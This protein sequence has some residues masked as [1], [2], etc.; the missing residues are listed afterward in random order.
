MRNLK[1]SILI[2]ISTLLFS[3]IEVFSQSSIISGIVVDDDQNQPI[4]FVHLYSLG[5]FGTTCNENGFF[6]VKLDSRQNNKDSA[7]FSAIGFHEKKIALAGLFSEDTLVIKLSKKEYHL[8]EVQI[9]PM[10]ETVFLG[11]DYA[12]GQLHLYFAS[13]IP[14]QIG[15]V[16]DVPFQAK[17]KSAHYYIKKTKYSKTPFRVRVYKY[18]TITNKPSTEVTKRRVLG[19][20]EKRKGWAK[21]NLED[22]NIFVQKEKIFVAFEVVFMGDDYYHEMKLMEEELQVYGATLT[23]CIYDRNKLYYKCFIKNYETNE[24]NEYRFSPDNLDVS[25]PLI[26]IELKK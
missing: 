7:I 20:L 3:C 21:I 14:F 15:I 22:E 26:K 17:L 6:R 18:D 25:F 2:S 8:N 13:S 5:N 24:W 19:K 23:N 9:T 11:P 10:E 4:P 16:I 1:W 12:S